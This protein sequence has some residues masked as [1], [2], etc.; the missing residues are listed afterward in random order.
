MTE[1]EKLMLDMLERT[2][3]TI[4]IENAKR[5]FPLNGLECELG[6]LIAKIKGT[7]FDSK[8]MLKDRNKLKKKFGQPVSV[9]YKQLLA[10]LY[11]LVTDHTKDVR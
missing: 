9:K 4:H 2:Y 5:E 6:E 3:K 1:D 11:Q 10:A 7:E 8:A